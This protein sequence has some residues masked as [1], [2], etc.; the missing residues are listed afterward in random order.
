M[1]E[2]LIILINDYREK[3]YRQFSKTQFLWQDLYM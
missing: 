1:K 3:M 2:I